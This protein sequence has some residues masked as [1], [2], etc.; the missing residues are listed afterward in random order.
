MLIK[1]KNEQLITKLF[2]TYHRNI[3]SDK[4]DTFIIEEALA[5]VLGKINGLL[6]NNGSYIVCGRQVEIT[7][8]DITRTKI[9]FNK[10]IDY[11]IRQTKNNITFFWTSFKLE[12]L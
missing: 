7:S 6:Q 10:D 8:I 11:V 5:T 12:F 4:N 3:K 9:I 2:H 1:E